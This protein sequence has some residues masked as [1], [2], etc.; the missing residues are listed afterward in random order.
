MRVLVTGGAGFIGSNLVDLLLHKGYQVRILDSL[1]KPTHLL[2]KPNWIPKEA[3]FI[4]GDVRDEKAV[5]QSLEGVDFVFH[6]AAAGGFMPEIKY[7]L[8]VNCV[9]TALLWESIIKKHRIK[10]FIMLLRK[11]CMEKEN[12][13]AKN[14]RQ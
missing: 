3:E 11:L 6:Q 7:Y 4:H 8:D 13:N 10:K 14:I 5:D 1:E 12:T 9:G 2:G